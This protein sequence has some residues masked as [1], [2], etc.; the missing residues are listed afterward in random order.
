MKSGSV[1]TINLAS[2]GN[3]F[4]YAIIIFFSKMIIFPAVLL[5][6]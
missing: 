5:T 6:M 3:K 2:Y 1:F 4:P